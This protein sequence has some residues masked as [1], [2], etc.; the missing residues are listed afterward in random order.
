M[1]LQTMAEA[2]VGSA[3]H[4]TY[5]RSQKNRPRELKAHVLRTMAEA[6][7]GSAR[8][9]MYERSQKNRPRELKSHVLQT[10]AEVSVGSAHST[11]SAHFFKN[12]EEKF[13]LIR[14]IDRNWKKRIIAR[15]EG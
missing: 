12:R 4:L 6:G 13:S 1:F 3:R 9:L 11:H 2:G 5:G 8:H 14:Q 15:K 10:M 7:V